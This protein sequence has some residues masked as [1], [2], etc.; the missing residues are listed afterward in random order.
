MMV[1]SFHL[2][3]FSCSSTINKFLLCHVVL[4]AT[5]SWWRMCLTSTHLKLCSPNKANKGPKQVSGGGW[6]GS[7]MLDQDSCWMFF[8]FF[9]HLDHFGEY[10]SVTQFCCNL[11]NAP[12]SACILKSVKLGF[13]LQQVFNQMNADECHSLLNPLKLCSTTCNTW[14]GKVPGG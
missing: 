7:V 5:E 3:P 12:H 13:V 9:L 1:L 4:G 14:L 2:L 6:S 11:M 10:G 8:A